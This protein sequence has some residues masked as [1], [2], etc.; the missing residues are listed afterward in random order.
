MKHGWRGWQ[1]DRGWTVSHTWHNACKTLRRLRLRGDES[2]CLMV[3]FLLAYK[4]LALITVFFKQKNC[5]TPHFLPLLFLPLCPPHSRTAFAMVTWCSKSGVL[6]MDGGGCG[7]LAMW[8]YFI[9]FNTEKRLRLQ[10]YGYFPPI[11][12]TCTH[13]LGFN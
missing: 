6:E 12:N 8:A 9:L 13:I 4:E 5:L 3:I 2:F 11:K 7:W 10:I 1:E